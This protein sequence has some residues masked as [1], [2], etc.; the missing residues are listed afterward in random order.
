MLF[1]KVYLSKP[2]LEK[3]IIN[4]LQNKWIISNYFIY[5]GQYL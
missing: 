5:I 1:S 2:W 4:D 3:T